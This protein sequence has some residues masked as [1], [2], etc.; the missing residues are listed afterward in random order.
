MGYA[1]YMT[2]I[3]E[4]FRNAETV[5]FTELLKESE[6]SH[7]ENSGIVVALNSC[8]RDFKNDCVKYSKDPVVTSQKYN[9][10]RFLE[11]NVFLDF[12]KD[13]NSGSRYIELSGYSNYLT[14]DYVIAE[15]SDV[16]MTK[17]LSKLH[18]VIMAD[19]KKIFMFYYKGTDQFYNFACHNLPDFNDVMVLLKNNIYSKISTFEKFETLMRPILTKKIND[20]LNVGYYKTSLEMG[21]KIYMLKEHLSF[22]E[23]MNKGMPT[24]DTFEVIKIRAVV[25]DGYKMPEIVYYL[26]DSPKYDKTMEFYDVEDRSLQIIKKNGSINARYRSEG[27]LVFFSKQDADDYYKNKLR[28][29]KERINSV[30]KDDAMAKY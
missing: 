24:V 8:I 2:K 27:K 4:S 1:N 15:N 7:R 20:Y 11:R 3:N 21:S 17:M 26:S 30:L 23:I 28:Q 14:S 16:V 29:V 12:V 9:I 10:E 22:D 13:T 6:L 5:P 19:M 25:N 18:N